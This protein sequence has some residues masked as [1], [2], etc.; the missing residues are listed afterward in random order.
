[1]RPGGRPAG[2]WIRTAG[3]LGLSA[4]LVFSPTALAATE[5]EQ[6]PNVILIVADDLGY[7]DIGAYGSEVVETPNIDAL[8]REGVRFTNG[9]VAAAVCSPSR[10]GLMTGRYPQRFGYH[11]NNNSGPGLPLSE[12]T[13]GERLTA[14]GYA[15]GYIGKW[16]LGWRRP[17]QRP[18]ARGFGSFFG[19]AAGSIF[20]EPDTPGVESWNRTP[21]PKRRERPIYRDNESVEERDYLTDAFTREALSFIDVHHNE[22]FFLY[23]AHYAPHV[24]LQA[25][26][27]Y[28]DRY[29]HVEDPRQ[30]ILAAMVSAVD[31]SVGAIRAHLER[32]GL[33]DNTLIWFLSDNGCALYTFGACTNRPLNGGK[34]YHYD[35][36]IRVP[37]V[38]HWPGRIDSAVFDD[39]VSALDIVPTIMAAA[40]APLA[41]GEVLDGVN[42]LAHLAE[43]ELPPP[44][45]SLFWRAGPNRAARIGS[46]K[47]WKVNRVDRARAES[48]PRGELLEDWVAPEGSPLGQLTLLYDLSVDVGERRNLAAERPDVVLRLEAALNAWDR[49]MRSPS[50]DSIRGTGTFI[51]GEPVEIIF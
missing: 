47:L 2:S 7:G 31:D 20:I 3:L 40:G 4:L 13:L 28:L 42:L 19:M 33:A 12:R 26:R 46:W 32:Y 15:T 36:G 11:F 21:V 39:P 51:D 23:L 44:H 45:D 9:Y 17:E 30:R 37:F 35:G 48:T 24:P 50:V 8:A 41:A 49:D 18:V 10:A 14:N 34:R 22:R 16:H 29:R 1:M 5:S 43:P 25:T 38:M 6:A 27:K